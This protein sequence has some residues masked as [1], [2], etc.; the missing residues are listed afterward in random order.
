M[1]RTP[2]AKKGDPAIAGR[3]EK[4][5]RPSRIYETPTK[6]RFMA[7]LRT[8]AWIT[9]AAEAAGWPARSV[10]DWLARGRVSL[11]AAERDENHKPDSP[12]HEF[13]AET[14]QVQAEA[15]VM[16]LGLIGRAARGDA[17]VFQ[18]P[19]WRAAAWMLEKRNPGRYGSRVQIAGDPTA[20]LNVA[21]VVPGMSEADRNRRAAEI[22]ASL[23][24]LGADP[25]IDGLPVEDLIKPQ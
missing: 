7:M 2:R 15:E 17:K 18:R 1:A 20:P 19:D 10:E 5:G 3:P 13:A 16:L 24:G 25:V 11:A 12:Y 4:P 22:I 14:S 9:E 23:H 21:V 6:T 8:G